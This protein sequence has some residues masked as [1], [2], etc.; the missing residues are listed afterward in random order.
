MNRL[1]LFI[2]LPVVSDY[3]EKRQVF[4]Q[5][6]NHSDVLL[7]LALGQ[8]WPLGNREKSFSDCVTQAHWSQ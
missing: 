5:V 3:M 7:Y 8:N 6:I 2:S 1:N 4:V